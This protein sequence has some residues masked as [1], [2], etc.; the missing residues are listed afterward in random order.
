MY[1]FECHGGYWLYFNIIKYFY[2]SWR[3]EAMAKTYVDQSITHVKKMAQTITGIEYEKNEEATAKPLNE[4]DAPCLQAHTAESDHSR[5][6]D[7]SECVKVENSDYQESS[8]QKKSL[9]NVRKK[10]KKSKLS[11]NKKG[12][13]IVKNIYNIQIGST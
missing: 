12:K 7:S 9:G 13:Q 11:L 5:E 10:H 4:D 6:N 2:F 3:S 1:D 8:P